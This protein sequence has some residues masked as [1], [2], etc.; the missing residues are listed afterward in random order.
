MTDFFGLCY[1]FPISCFNTRAAALFTDPR[2]VNIS[3]NVRQRKGGMMGVK[4]APYKRQLDAPL[5]SIRSSIIFSIG[6]QYPGATWDICFSWRVC[7]HLY[8][9][10][11]TRE[12]QLGFFVVVVDHDA[13]GLGLPVTPVVWNAIQFCMELVILSLDVHSVWSIFS[14]KSI[15]PGGCVGKVKS[16]AM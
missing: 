10:T 3:P 4:K 2:G 7:S 6:F 12:N 15:N 14:S 11:L 13:T 5:W 9:S 16:M 1:A 8:R